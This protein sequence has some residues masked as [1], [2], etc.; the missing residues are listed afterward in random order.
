MSP[1]S[2]MAFAAVAAVVLSTSVAADVSI[3]SLP[4]PLSLTPT[5]ANS[6]LYVNTVYPH[7]P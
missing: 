7:K 5:Y 1:P 4:F 3:S 2:A 6:D